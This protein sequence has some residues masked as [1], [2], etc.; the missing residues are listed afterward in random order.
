MEEKYE[1]IYTFKDL[2]DDNHIYRENKD[3]YPRDGLKPSKKRIKE[4]TTTENKIGKVL[5]KKIEEV[6]EETEVTE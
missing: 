4:L 2:K 1:V 3:F 5:I 6:T